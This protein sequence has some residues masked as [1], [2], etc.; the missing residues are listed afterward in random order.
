MNTTSIRKPLP[1]SGVRSAA[2]TSLL[3]RL[4]Q[5]LRAIDNQ[6]KTPMSAQKIVVFLS[7]YLVLAANWPLWFQLARIGGAPSLYMRSAFILGVLTACGLIAI[8]AFTAWTRGFRLLW[9]AVA[10]VAALSQYYMLT[11]SVVMDPGMA[12]NVLQTDAHEVAD[13]LGWRLFIGVMLVFTIPLW[14]L[15]RVRIPAMS[16]VRQSVRNALLLV[17]SLAVAAAII[18]T[19]SRD[20][21]PLMRNNPQ[22]R[23]MLNPIA[24]LYSTSV[25]VIRPLIT[26][27]KSLVPMGAGAA[28]GQS[29]ADQKKPP[30][31]VLV[32]GETGRADHFGLNGY[33]R[34]TTPQLAARDVVNWKDVH[35]CGTSTLASVPCM[36]SPLGKKAFESRKDDYETLLDVVQAAGMYVLWVDNQSGCKGVCDRV[37]HASASDGLNSEQRKRYCDA[38]GECRDMVMLDNIDQRIAAIPADKRANG[39]LLVLHQMGS[40]GPAYSKRSSAATKQFKPECTTEVLADCAHTELMNAYDNSILETDKFLGRTIDWLKTQSSTY[41]TGMLYLSDH[42]ESLGEYGQFLHGLPY[43]IAPEVQK[44]VPMVAWLDADLLKRGHLSEQCLKGTADTP[45][46]HDNLYHSML[47]ILDVKSPSYEPTLDIFAQCR[48]G[49]VAQAK[50]A[51]GSQT[52]F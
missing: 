48:A 9:L 13:L 7:I 34:D 50:P 26:K 39:V 31:F 47:G 2:D 43:S 15:L 11:Y 19:M 49:A 14:W 24:S 36:F 16:V 33:A 25:S 22:L 37:P 52:E 27:R 28:L 46:T 51:A 6:F 1:T 30:L 40:H 44:H 23:Y 20:L 5:P 12:A 42:G 17:V 8:L 4:M 45:Y 38:S 10:F 32:V 41:D 29:F 18:G 35:S 3:S 21:A